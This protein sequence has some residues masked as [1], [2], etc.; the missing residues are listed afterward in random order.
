MTKQ[1]TPMC[2]NVCDLHLCVGSPGT[3]N[4]FGDLVV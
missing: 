4:Y 2:E 3:N 1:F